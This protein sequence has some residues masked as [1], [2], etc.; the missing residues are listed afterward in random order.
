[1]KN[2]D[3]RQVLA[4][5]KMYSLFADVVGG[6]S[7][8]RYV[9]Q[10]IRPRE[11]D[12]LLDIGCGPA[13]ILNYLPA[14]VAYTGFDASASYIDS[15]RARFGE[16]GSFFC[17]RVDEAVIQRIGR[18]DVAIAT[19]VLHHLDDAESVDLF[20]IARHALVP[21]GRLITLDGAYT[22]DQSALARYIISKDRGQ[23]VR[24]AEAYEKLARQVFPDVK[25]HIR[26]DMM[27]IPYTHIIMECTAAEGGD[28]GNR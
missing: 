7:R 3:L 10:Y 5:P 23:H 2:F 14:S 11:G 28:G 24:P 15:A 12:R 6:D 21:G 18:F 1:M 4:L 8:R 19:G 25:V 16:R 27:R 22:A 13:D 26:H 9:E 17:E 20:R